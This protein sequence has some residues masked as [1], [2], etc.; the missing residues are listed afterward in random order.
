[1][2]RKIITAITYRMI[3]GMNHGLDEL[4]NWAMC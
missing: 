2:M 3:A 4:L 1:M